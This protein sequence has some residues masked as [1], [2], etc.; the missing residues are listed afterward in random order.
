MTTAKGKTLLFCI[1]VND[2]SLPARGSPLREGRVIG[3]LAEAIQ[4]HAP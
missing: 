4:Q 3:T 2:V 1:F